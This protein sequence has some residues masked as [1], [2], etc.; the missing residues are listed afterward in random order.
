MKITLCIVN[1]NGAVHLRDSLP[2]VIEL[3]RAVDEVLL[4]DNASTDGGQDFF[5]QSVP[6]GR[7]IQLTE[8]RSPGAARS[9][10][11]LPA[12]TKMSGLRAASSRKLSS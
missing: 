5:L 8:N 12:A 2:C 6:D 11:S 10:G 4:L 9:A 7:V 1:H 3:G